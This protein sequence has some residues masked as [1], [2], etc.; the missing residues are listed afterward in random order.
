LEALGG[1]LVNFSRGR[2]EAW[3]LSQR[4]TG[5]CNRSSVAFADLGGM[6][7]ICFAVFPDC[8]AAIDLGRER[9]R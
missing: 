7:V 5:C 6:L 8:L 1:A 9:V 3:R 2:R 4:R